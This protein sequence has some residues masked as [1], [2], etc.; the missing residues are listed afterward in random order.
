[1][2]LNKNQ[3]QDM[4]SKTII[5]KN[6]V[7]QIK[8]PSGNETS[9]TLNYSTTGHFVGSCFVAD[10]NELYNLGAALCDIADELSGVPLRQTMVNEFNRL[11]RNATET[12]KESPAANTP[13]E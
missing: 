11:A 2:G 3:I 5:Q 13:Q 10:A 9:V 6:Q 4:S 7:Y 12:V 8:L 1:M